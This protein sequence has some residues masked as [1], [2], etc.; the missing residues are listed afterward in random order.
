MLSRRC[1]G[2]GLMMKLLLVYVHAT[3]SLDRDVWLGVL[4][5]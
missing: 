3:D 5:V 1:L 2:E 4:F